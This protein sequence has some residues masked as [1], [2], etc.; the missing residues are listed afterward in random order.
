MPSWVYEI[1]QKQ[2]NKSIYVGST[3]GKYFCLRKGEHTRPS[4]VTSGR[5]PKLYGF[6]YENGGWEQFQFNILREFETIEKKE[7]LTLEKQYI[8]ERSPLCNTSKPIQSRE[9]YLERRRIRLQTWRKNHPEYLEKQKT[10]QSQK[11]YI[12]KRCSTKINCECGGVYTLQN[13]TNHFSRQIHKR[14][15]DAKAK[16]AT[17]NDTQI[18]QT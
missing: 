10:Y 7:L 2:T 6:I 17:G 9:E 3:T 5:Q 15:E 12:A 8:N 13:K 16:D 11:D 4:N 14:Y 1:I 18:P